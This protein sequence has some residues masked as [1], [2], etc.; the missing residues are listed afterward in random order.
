MTAKEAKETCQ[1]QDCQC[2]TCGNDHT[3]VCAADEGNCLEV[4][5]TERC[6]V[7]RCANWVDKKSIKNF[8]LYGCA[9]CL[10][11]NGDVITFAF[12]S[13]GNIQNGVMTPIG[14]PLCGNERS[15]SN[16]QSI[17]CPVG[18]VERTCG[19]YGR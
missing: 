12:Q 8:I 6:P 9:D 13:G 5:N 18:G 2:K 17:P 15:R 4:Q 1:H 19:P 14:C 16:I 11:D 10:D 3:G 7:R